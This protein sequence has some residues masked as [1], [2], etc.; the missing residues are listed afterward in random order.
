MALRSISDAEEARIDA[1]FD[2]LQMFIEDV[3]EDPSILEQIPDQSSLEFTP[4]EEK[5]PDGSYVT[6]TRRLAISLGAAP[7]SSEASGD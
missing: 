5:S 3:I 4:I 7:E 6:E 2:H 1:I